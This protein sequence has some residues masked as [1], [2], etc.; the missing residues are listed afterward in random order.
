MTEPKK[1][2]RKKKYFPNNWKEIKEAPAEL[3]DSLPFDEFMNWKI[4]G[5]QLPSNVTCIIR[6]TNYVTGKVKEYTYQR[7][8]AAKKRANQII[9]SQQSEF[10]VCNSEQVY[11]M[12]PQLTDEYD[13]DDPLA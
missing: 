1:K 13:Y 6:E 3:F 5:W 9:N 4:G 12:Y 7:P 11:H 10:L 8:E 2:K